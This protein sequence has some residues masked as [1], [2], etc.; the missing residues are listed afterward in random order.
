MSVRRL[1]GLTV[2]ADTIQQFSSAQVPSSG[3]TLLAG[4]SLPDGNYQVS[5]NTGQTLTIEESFSVTYTVPPSGAV[6]YSLHVQL[7]S[8]LTD[9]AFKLTGLPAGKELTLTLSGTGFFALRNM[10]WV[11]TGLNPGESVT[12][13]IAAIFG[14]SGNASI[15]SELDQNG[16]T[17][18]LPTM[19]VWG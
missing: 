8:S 3:A 11:V 15:D 10:K 12:S 13:T 18:I 16:A 17:A 19:E 6:V 4:V 9:T 2:P 5:G 14:G 7:D 1:P